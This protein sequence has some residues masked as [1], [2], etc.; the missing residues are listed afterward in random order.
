VNE[1]CGTMKQRSKVRMCELVFSKRQQ[2]RPQI[3]LC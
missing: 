1:C 3:M 2:L